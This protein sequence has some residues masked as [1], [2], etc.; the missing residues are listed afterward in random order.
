MPPG[1]RSS[2]PVSR[3]A[4]L[5]DYNRSNDDDDDDDGRQNMFAGGEKSYIPPLALR[6][7]NKKGASQSRIPVTMPLR[8]KCVISLAEQYKHLR[9]LHRKHVPRTLAVQGIPL[10]LNPRHRNRSD[11][12]SHSNDVKD[13]L[14]VN[15]R[16][17]GM[18]SP[19]MM[20]HY[21]RIIIRR[22]WRF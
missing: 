9:P 6:K 5:G 20:A 8:M 21:L 4:T 2:A 1:Q 10:D 3:F 17:G 7:S 13:L 14:N 11:N 15:S 16:Y 19:L 18:D 12:P 22:V